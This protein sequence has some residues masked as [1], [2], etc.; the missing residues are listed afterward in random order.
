VTQDYGGCR[1]VGILG[2][3]GGVEDTHRQHA[4][5]DIADINPLVGDEAW[6]GLHER[7][8]L[9]LNEA[10]QF[11]RISDDVV[12]A[13]SGVHGRL[14]VLN[15]GPSNLGQMVGQRPLIAKLRVA[16]LVRPHLPQPCSGTSL[17]NGGALPITVPIR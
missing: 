3:L 2:V 11:R 16:L 6:K 9:L 17:R 12:L 14:S 15:P 4:P 7:H 13:N 10:I 5:T 8:E 1:F